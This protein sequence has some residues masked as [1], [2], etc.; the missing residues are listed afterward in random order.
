[1]GGL[2]TTFTWW[3]KDMLDMKQNQEYTI[4]KLQFCTVTATRIKNRF[5]PKVVIS[6]EH[7]LVL[8]EESLEIATTFAISYN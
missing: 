3:V 4:A 5:I 1:M 8:E 6:P 7:V 2:T